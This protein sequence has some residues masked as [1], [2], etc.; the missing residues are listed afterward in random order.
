[1]KKYLKI[2]ALFIATLAINI[3]LYAHDVVKDIE[4]ISKS[5]AGLF[6]VNMGFK[7]IIPLGFDHILFII[8]LC[9]ANKS[10]KSLLWKS[11]AFTLGHCFTLGIAML[12]YFKLSPNIV[13]PIIALTIIYVAIENL[14]LKQEAKHRIALI[15]VFGLLHGLGFASA[16]S[17]IGLP[18]S[19]FLLSLITFN[20]GLELGQ[21]AVILGFFG[22]K[23][24]VEM[25]QKTL[26][27]HLQLGLS[28]IIILISIFWFFER[29]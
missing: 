10:Y 17:E 19:Q 5:E 4:N 9:F 8:T 7:H 12:G 27:K 29:I 6:Y 26:W 24:F 14:L 3:P 23:Y 13:E 25:Y 15:F 22:I 28:A 1:M 21:L 11:L 2:T 20:F 16:L 18:K